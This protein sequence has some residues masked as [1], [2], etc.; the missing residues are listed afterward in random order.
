MRRNSQKRENR[1]S[2]RPQRKG[3]TIIGRTWIFRGIDRGRVTRKTITMH[4]LIGLKVKVIKS[5]H[6]GL[7]GIEGYV[8]DETRNTLTIL[9]EKVWIV[10]KNVAEFE[11]EID[12]KKIRIKG[13]ELIGR[14]EMRLKK[15]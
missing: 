8:I 7:I 9:G 3:E 10:P 15:R 4:E 5:S 1:A 13:E 2:R 11:F 6:P 14:P 12:D